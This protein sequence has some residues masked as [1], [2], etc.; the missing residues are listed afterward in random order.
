MTKFF[1][2]ILTKILSSFDNNTK[3]FSARKLSAFAGVIVCIYATVH[4]VDT[5]TVVDALKVWL[6]FALLCLGIITVEQLIK[7][8]NGQNE[9]PKPDDKLPDDQPPVQ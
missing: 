1:L 6:V 4:Y 9:P 3:G 7:L 2:T 5:S 8:K